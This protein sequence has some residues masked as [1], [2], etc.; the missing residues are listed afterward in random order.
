MNI[1]NKK[2]T[3]IALVL[4]VLS[5]SAFTTL[6][7][8]EIAL[9]DD[10]ETIILT[11]PDDPYVMPKECIDLDGKSSEISN[12]ETESEDSGTDGSTSAP[13]SDSYTKKGTEEYRVA[14]SIFDTWTKELGASGTTAAAV[15]GVMY[16]ESQ[17]VEDRAEQTAGPIN[18][19]MNGKKPPATMKNYSPRVFD[20]IDKNGNRKQ[21]SWG[22]GGLIQFTPFQK[23]TESKFWNKNGKGGW[24]AGNQMEFIWDTE[25]KNRYV[26]L[27][28]ASYGTPHSTIEQFMQ[29]DNLEDSVKTF[30][31]GFGKPAAGVEREDVR[32]EA[33]N[34]INKMFN[35]SNIKADKSKWKLGSN[36]SDDNSTTI[37]TEEED[38]ML[39]SDESSSNSKDIDCGPKEKEEKGSGLFGL[40]GTGSHNYKDGQTWSNSDLP[41]DLQQYNLNPEL[42]DM[43]YG[44]SDNWFDLGTVGENPAGSQCTHFASS[45]FARVWTE[46]GK[47]PI[48]DKETPSGACVWGS[49]CNGRDLA[50]VWSKHLGG[51]L[52]SEPRTGAIASVDMPGTKYGHVFMVSHVFENGDIL[53]IEQNWTHTGTTARDS[54]KG[55]TT[56][57]WEYRIQSKES[58]KKN[59][60]KF[61]RPDDL[62]PNE[63]YGSEGGEG[64]V[65]AS[66]DIKAMFKE[67]KRLVDSN[68]IYNQLDTSKGP[69]RWPNGSEIGKQFP[70]NRATD[71]SAFVRYLWYRHFNVDIGNATGDQMTSP[72]MKTVSKNNMKPGDLIYN[73]NG[74]HVM[75]WMGNGQVMHAA[76]WNDDL[77][78]NPYNPNNDPTFVMVRRPI[79]KK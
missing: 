47:T 27:S 15:A 45:L 48:E 64:S 77:K 8:Q 44:K 5:S 54:G 38:S 62:K 53:I 59:G 72:K 13:T 68:V 9:A 71:C 78:I 24:E 75:M 34:K 40:E 70:M 51:S 29:S 2:I 61:Y 67:G 35:K 73:A 6:F 60:T 25:F 31:Y 30:L 12:E 11:R 74:G 21:S 26:E 65:P 28:M 42:V 69:I 14:K 1:M 36:S 20:Y 32:L 33:A 43:N 50:G 57:T 56:Y 39:G 41:E 49:P 18:F 46:D 7:G 58:Y 66:A 3:K 52:S 16:G 79:V 37:N 10:T 55:L 63:A 76:N 17:F 4:S 23:Y 19:G 22:G